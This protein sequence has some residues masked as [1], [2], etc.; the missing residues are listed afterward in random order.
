MYNE[1]NENSKL[2]IFTIMQKKNLLFK[3]LYIQVSKNIFFI[4]TCNI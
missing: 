1:L 4:S 2:N 3:V